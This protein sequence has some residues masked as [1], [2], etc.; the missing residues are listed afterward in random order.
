MNTMKIFLLG[1][2]GVVVINFS[3][4]SIS[5]Q[6]QNVQ[7]DSLVI[8]HTSAPP[9]INGIGDDSCWQTAKWQSIGKVWIPF[10][11]SVTDIDYTGRYKVMFSSETNLLYFLIEIHDDVLVDGYV[12]SRYGGSY[13]FDITEVFIDENCSG[14]EHRYDGST[15][16]A[17][18]AFAYHMYAAYPAEGEVNTSPYIEDMIGTQ[19]NSKWV[20]QASHFPEFIM[21]KTG[22]TVVRE[23][24][25]IVYDDTYTEENK[26]SARVELEAGKILGLSLAYCDNDHPEKNPKVRDNMYGSVDE[27]FP[28][29]SH[30]MNADYF[31]TAVLADNLITG[32]NSSKTN[33]VQFKLFQNY[34]N[35]FNPNT[36]ISY[37]VPMLSD[38]TLKIYDVLGRE[39]SMLVNEEKKVGS[40]EVNFDGSNLTSGIYFYK[41]T[42]GK[43]S[44]TNK[45]MLLK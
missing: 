2:F 21:R 7:D 9:I 38:V 43:F 20:D 35:P 25:L 45:M 16:N 5:A 4:Q 31:G 1:F 33:P 42:V 14:G 27:P 23:F 11:G 26:D 8:L 32:I 3:S 40:Y 12:P 19:A 37:N 44:E 34:P 36:V 39:I 28:G 13:N 15:S 24:S 10:S 22:N 30:W 29:N 17:E 18:N 41:L 6:S